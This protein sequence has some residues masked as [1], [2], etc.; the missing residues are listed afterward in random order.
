MRPSDLDLSRRVPLFRDLPPALVDQL[1][2]GT[3]VQTLPRGTMLCRQGE[4]PEFLHVV[5]SGRVALVGEGGHHEETVVEFFEAGDVLIAPAVMLEAPYLMSARV[6]LEARVLFIPAT[7]LRRALKL[8]PALSYAMAMQLAAYWRRLIQQI[9]DLKLHTSTERLAT[10][11]VGLAADDT[12]EARVELPE[13]RKVV[14]TRLGMTPES[15][16][17]AFAS[18]RVIGVAGRGRQVSIASVDRLRESCQY[19]GIR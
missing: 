11:L 16:S 15:L 3:F 14:A 7:Q 6:A 2:H 4:M 13:D 9:K 10:F 19:D 1:M 17:R 12:G 5:L 8:E 18:L